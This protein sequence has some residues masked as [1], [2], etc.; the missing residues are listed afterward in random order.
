MR[1]MALEL[2]ENSAWLGRCA[3]FRKQDEGLVVPLISRG[4]L[5]IEF[6]SKR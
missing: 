2:K 5:L 4:Q 6:F 1:S 3:G